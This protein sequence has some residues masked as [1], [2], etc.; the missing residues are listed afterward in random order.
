[1]ELARATAGASH[2]ATIVQK[3]STISGARSRLAKYRSTNRSTVVLTELDMG[4]VA[5]PAARL[6]AHSAKDVRRT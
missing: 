2:S 4:E 6:I 3:G 1:M 5:A